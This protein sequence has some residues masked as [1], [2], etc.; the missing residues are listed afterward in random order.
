MDH[1]DIKSKDFSS[2]NK[3]HTNG[4]QLV[5]KTGNGEQMHGMV[6]GLGSVSGL[7]SKEGR[8]SMI[9]RNFARFLMMG[10]FPASVPGCFGDE[11]VCSFGFKTGRRHCFLFG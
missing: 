7:S 5:V 3:T 9:N 8:M 6:P 4:G 1:T 10:I 2:G 11:G